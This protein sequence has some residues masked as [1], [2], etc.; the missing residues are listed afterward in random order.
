MS[1]RELSLDRTDIE[2]RDVL[3]A[4]PEMQETEVKGYSVFIVTGNCQKVKVSIS[5]G[6]EQVEKIIR[7][8]E[9]P[10]EKAMKNAFVMCRKAKDYYR[11]FGLHASIQRVGDKLWKRE[12]SSYEE[13]LRRHIPSKMVLRKQRKQQ[14]SYMPKISIV[15]PL[16]KTP[17]KYLREMIAS[18]QE[19]SYQNWELCLSDGSGE[20]SP[21]KSIL[22][23]YERK[24]A[25]IRVVHNEK[26]LHISDNTNEALKICTGNY[27]AFTDHDDLLTP[28]ALYE[29]VRV[30]NEYPETELIYSDED[31]VNM[32]GT[33]YFM[34][35]FKSDF[36]IDMLRSTNYFC[37]LVM[38]K[39]ELLL[40]AGMLRSEYDGSQDYDFV[41]RC[42]E[43]TDKIYHIPK[44]LYHWR[45][46]EGS[47]AQKADNKS[48]GV[49][50][51][52]KAVKAHYERV[53][54]DAEVIPT[55]YPGMYWSK[56]RIT[57]EPMI[58]V[59]IPN[60][61]HVDDLEKCVRS[62]EEKCTYKNLEIIIVENNSQE[63][64]T[65]AYYKELE[66]RNEKVKVLYWPGTGFN[67]PSINNFGVKH[68]NGEYLVLLNNDTEVVSEDCMEE[69]LGYCMRND[70]GAVGARLYYADGT[71]QHAGVIVGLGGVACHAFVGS[72]PEDPGYFARAAIAHDLS[73]VTAACMMVKKSVYE[74]VG[75]LD[76]TFAVAFNDVDLCIKIR[77]AGYLVVYNP[78]AE[79]MHY[80]SKS[81][82]YEDTAEKQQR[83]LS[84]IRLFQ[85]R[86]ADFLEKGDPYYNPNLTL[87][88]AD[89]RLHLGPKRERIIHVR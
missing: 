61:D 25:R 8:E 81:R 11:Q 33:E 2:R 76:E 28:N 57:E 55:P 77:E 75:G 14:F 67:Y 72:A 26:Q 69:L 86:W 9:P 78:K 53:G 66:K 68:A 45:A 88:G 34:P 89:F 3:L 51:G 44:I 60:K 70:V 54:I 84:E 23:E 82:G 71:L 46:C 59:I 65:F 52:R 13:W 87:D 38:V 27:I 5:N 19:Q 17:E 15:V 7:I 85:S 50:A 35:H 62:L 24:D 16:Y 4:Y 49:E 47:T 12:L 43:Q 1:G 79:L 18:V 56:Y 20:D 22:Q 58:S 39:K 29:C 10:V 63:E 73:A 32:D 80:E 64:K 21:I 6:R 48:Y 74:E 42:V 30:L 41:L 37:H 36:N 40:R 83:F 31:K